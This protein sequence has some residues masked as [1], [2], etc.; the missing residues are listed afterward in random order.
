MLISAPQACLV[1]QRSE[2][3]HVG[4]GDGTGRCWANPPA[5]NRCSFFLKAEKL[6]SEW[7]LTISRA[8]L[9]FTW[10]LLHTLPEAKSLHPGQDLS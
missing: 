6:P 8:S 2:G 1:S 9:K 4:A 10:L 3:H 5:Q 7:G